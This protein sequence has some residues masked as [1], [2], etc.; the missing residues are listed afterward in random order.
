MKTKTQITADIV[1]F[2][3]T[4]MLSACSSNSGD[5]AITTTNTTLSCS[6][7][8]NLN[9][10]FSVN[11]SGQQNCYDE[12]GLSISCPLSNASL[13]GQDAQ[14]TTV[15]PA[16]EICDDSVVVDNN[17]KLMWQK[18]HN[19]TRVSYTNAE[20][21]CAN[22]TLG[23]F[24]D[25]R[26]PEVK[27]AFSIANFA[28]T[29]DDSNS[30]SPSNPYLFADYFDISYDVNELLTGSHTAQMMG[31]TWTAT[32]RPDNININYFYNFLDGHLKSQFN[33]NPD[34]TLFYRCVRGEKN[35][36]NN[37][38]NNADGT[39]TDNA[40]GL[41]WQTENAY[42]TANSSYQF[43]WSE[44]LSF[45]ETSTQAGYSDWQ[46][47]D[48]K[49]LH[50]IV[51][52]SDASNSI[53]TSVFTQTITPDTGPFFWSSTTDEETPHFADYICFG[54]CWNYLLNADIHGPGAQ[55][56]SPKYDNGNLPTSFG[57]QEDLVQVNNYVRC[58]R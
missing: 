41:M 26:I 10:N 58:V 47:P 38:T 44:A 56:S 48:I 32:S 35:F 46:L 49:A 23:G 52:Y 39:V 19:E 45:C 18:D 2:I 17:T 14:Y 42:N 50:S 43:T 24:S 57:D 8:T 16:F 5:N 30:T 37:L 28:G 12:N 55:R 22:L 21:A 54:P 4:L 13:Y 9:T 53:N 51:D 7:Y 36:S 29:I 3:S 11:D 27:E 1:F 15:T 34:S 20:S 40:T 33:N 31:Q 25:W 6:T